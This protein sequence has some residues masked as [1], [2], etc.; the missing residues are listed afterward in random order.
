MD[1]AI[2]AYVGFQQRVLMHTL[3]EADAL[4][5]QGEDEG[6]GEDDEDGEEERGAAGADAEREGGVV[7]AKRPRA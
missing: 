4:E 3:S 2:D 6:N 1:A 5:G 7:G